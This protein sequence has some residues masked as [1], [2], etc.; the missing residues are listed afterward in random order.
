MSREQECFKDVQ[1]GKKIYFQA[2]GSNFHQSFR[3]VMSTIL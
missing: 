2:M 1:I 3:L